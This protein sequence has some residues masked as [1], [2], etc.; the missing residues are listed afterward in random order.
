M[1]EQCNHSIEDVIR[2]TMSLQ[3]YWCLML[4]S[5][6]FALRTVQHSST[7]FSPFHLLCNY[8]PI[9]HFEYADKLR[10]GILSDVDS[11]D[12]SV[13]PDGEG[14]GTTEFDPLLSKIQY[15]EDQRKGTFD[16]ASQSIKKAQKHQAKDYNNRQNKGKPLRLAKNASKEIVQMTST[17]LK[18]KNKF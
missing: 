14:S 11:D 13:S 5:V 7:G 2:K 8:D 10:N 1:V 12:D 9:L 17:K 6:L 18:C 15:L 4:P 16:K 3:S